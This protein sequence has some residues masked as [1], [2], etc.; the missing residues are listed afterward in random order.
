M[1]LAVAQAE[2]RA[3]TP[4]ERHV[5]HAAADLLQAKLRRIIRR[6]GRTGERRAAGRSFGDVIDRLAT[7]SIERGGAVSVI[8]VSNANAAF[9]PGVTQRWVAR[10]RGSLRSADLVGMLGEGEVALLLP[11][12]AGDQAREVASRVEKLARDAGEFGPRMRLGIASRR[13]GEEWAGNIIQQARENVTQH[14]SE[15]LQ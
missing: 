14:Q 8:V 10:I 3:I 2:K 1:V 15:L 6:G 4:H 12:T 11:D 7:L 13:P 5:A 9:Q